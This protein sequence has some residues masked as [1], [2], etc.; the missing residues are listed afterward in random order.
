MFR[1]SLLTA[2]L[3]LTTLFASTQEIKEPKTTAE[4]TAAYQ[5]FRIAG[6][7]Y[8]VGTYDL[9]CYLIT[10]SQGNILINTGLAASLDQIKSNIETLGFKFSDIK[11]LLTTQAHYDHMGAMA[12]I[13]K[14]TGAQLMVDE[15]DADVLA[16]GGSSDYALG[17]YGITFKPV[18]PDRLL[19]D[20]DT[21]KL[22]NMQLVT[23]HHP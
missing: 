22:G 19:H 15:K 18:K 20:N 9:G 12:A 16:T 17:K 3:S 7:L 8:Y 11:I 13:K 21:I 6:N 10:T 4:W 14:A 23:L 2:V 5:P 1:S